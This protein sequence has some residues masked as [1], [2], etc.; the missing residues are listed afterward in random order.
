MNKQN[1]EAVKITRTLPVYAAAGF[2]VTDCVN[3]KDPIGHAD[4]LVLDDVYTLA[5][6]IRQVPL[7]IDRQNTDYFVIADGSPTGKSGNRVFPDCAVTLMGND[8]TGT[9]KNPPKS[10]LTG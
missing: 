9:S 2:C 5:E 3:Y 8:L 7:I 6:N 1:T 10:G 4:E